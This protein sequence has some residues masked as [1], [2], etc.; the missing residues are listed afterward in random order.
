MA[1]SLSMLN[2]GGRSCRGA[3]VSRCRLSLQAR[4]SSMATSM[5]TSSLEAAAVMLFKLKPGPEC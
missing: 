4:C 2:R 3:T 1:A 5:T